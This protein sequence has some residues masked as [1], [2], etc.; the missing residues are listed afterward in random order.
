MDKYENSPVN[1]CCRLLGLARINNAFLTVLYG[2]LAD[3]ANFD[4]FLTG[5]LFIKDL[6]VS[7]FTDRTFAPAMGRQFIDTFS[8]V[9]FS[10]LFLLLFGGFFRVLLGLFVRSAFGV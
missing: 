1:Y 9:G 3:F 7:S 10:H 6:H 5:I 2:R 8:S 4:F